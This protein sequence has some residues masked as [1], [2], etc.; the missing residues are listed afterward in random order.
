MESKDII[1]WLILASVLGL[2]LPGYLSGASKDEAVQASRAATEWREANQAKI[3][4]VEYLELELVALRAQNVQLMTML[5]Y[6]PCEGG[7]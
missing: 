4:R 1:P 5:N 2:E 7:P 3:D 6:Q